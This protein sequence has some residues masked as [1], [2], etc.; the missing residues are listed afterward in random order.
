MPAT[1]VHREMMQ[2]VPAAKE[3]RTLSET[4]PTPDIPIVNIWCSVDSRSDFVMK[5]WNFLFLVDLYSLNLPHLLLSDFQECLSIISKEGV[6][7]YCFYSKHIDIQLHLG[8]LSVWTLRCVHDCSPQSILKHNFMSTAAT[9]Q[10]ASPGTAS[11]VASQG[12]E[13]MPWGHR[14]Q[15]EKKWLV[16]R[17][18]RVKTLHKYILHWIFQVRTFTFTFYFLFIYFYLTFYLTIVKEI[19]LNPLAKISDHYTWSLGPFFTGIHQ[20]W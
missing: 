4:L 5:C 10:Y 11:H 14:E 19:W 12:A 18:L 17:T 15:F 13:K 7:S 1:Q 3:S 8:N 20:M 16:M 9:C 2:K 6:W